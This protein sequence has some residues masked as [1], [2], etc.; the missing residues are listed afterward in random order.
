MPVLGL[1][2]R[3]RVSHS[4]TALCRARHPGTA[5]CR[6]RHPG[7]ALCRTRHP[8]TASC[9][10]ISGGSCRSVGHQP[11]GTWCL[12]LGGGCQ[13]GAQMRIRPWREGRGCQAAGEQHFRSK[14]LRCVCGSG[15]RGG[16]RGCQAAGEQRLRSTGKGHRRSCRGGGLLGCRVTVCMW[17]GGGCRAHSEVRGPGGRRYE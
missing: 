2:E 17:V 10:L 6:T 3:S 5:L 8:G 16:P 12:V 14:G 4:G 13:A 15:A 9:D 11:G 1:V 7:T